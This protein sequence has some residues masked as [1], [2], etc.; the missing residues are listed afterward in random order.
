M[1]E[2]VPAGHLARGDL[3]AEPGPALVDVAVVPGGGEAIRRGEPRHPGADDGDP[4]V[5]RAS[6]ASAAVTSPR[7][8][9]SGRPLTSS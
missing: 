2:P 1:L 6:S 5:L 4:H 8:T 3:A 7:T 9:Y